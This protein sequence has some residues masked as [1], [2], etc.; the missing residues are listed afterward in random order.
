M[1]VSKRA[2]PHGLFPSA[3]CTGSVEGRT[4]GA[5]AARWEVSKGG[6]MPSSERSPGGWQYATVCSSNMNRS[7]E[8]HFQ[9]LKVS[10]RPSCSIPASTE[11]G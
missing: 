6:G 11:C 4:P 7:M 9:M 1:G 2:S 3:D 10:C 5:R 8:A